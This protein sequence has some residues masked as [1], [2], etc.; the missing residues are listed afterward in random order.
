M[1]GHLAQ[2]ARHSTVSLKAESGISWSQR[3]QIITEQRELL[4][5]GSNVVE[6][7]SSAEETCNE[8]EANS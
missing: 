7:Q 2:I 8:V 6:M 4:E 5:V 1:E 3:G